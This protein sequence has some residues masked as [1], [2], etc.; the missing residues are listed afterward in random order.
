MRNLLRKVHDTIFGSYI[1]ELKRETNNYSSILDVGCGVDSP[2]QYL[3]SNMNKVGVD[4]YGPA[5][6]ASKQ[7]GIHNEYF[8]I[9]VDDI[10]KQFGPNSF[11]CAIA[12][13]VI[14]HVTKEKGLA[15]IDKM[16]KVAK[17]KVII[18]TPHGFVPQDEHDG[19]P[20]Q[21]HLSGWEVSEMEERGYSVIGINGM[22]WV[23]NIEFLWK[24]R[25]DANFFVRVLRKIL[26]DITQLYARRNPKSAYQ[27]LCIKTLM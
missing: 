11:D 12:S 19:N 9:D 3:S 5:I 1:E 21:K 27:I 2:V 22:K 17:H 6:Q 18:F 24:K 14:E 16:E 23:W 25:E 26:V 20:W 10:D 4:V 15:L 13:D 7:K 8:E